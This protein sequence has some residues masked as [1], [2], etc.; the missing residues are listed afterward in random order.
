MPV[1]GGSFPAVAPGPYFLIVQVSS[2]DDTTPGNNTSAASPI[3]FNPKNID[4]QVNPVSSTGGTTAGA[5]MA[6]DFSIKNIGGAN[7]GA[8]VFWQVRA[9]VDTTFDVSDYIVAGGSIL[10]GL[11]AGVTSPITVNGTWPSTPGPWYLIAAAVAVDDINNVNDVISR[12]HW[13]PPR[14]LP[15]P[16]SNTQ[17]YR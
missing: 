16:M 7:G 1:T 10:G 8:T 17:S 11:N 9:S 5:A 2:A 6:G 12:Q 4:Y 13:L 15:R 14:A 3:T